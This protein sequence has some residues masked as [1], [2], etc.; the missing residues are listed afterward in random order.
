[1][2]NTLGSNPTGNLIEI[3]NGKLYG[4][5]YGGGVFA[6]FPGTLF[7]FDINTN[8]LTK[9][10]DFDG[11]LLG[12]NPYPLVN[13][14]NGKLYGVCRNG[15]TNV[16]TNPNNG[17]TYTTHNGTLFEYTPAT[18]VIN[19]LYDFGPTNTNGILADSGS[20]P[21]SLMKTSNGYYMGTG[22]Q[23]PFKFDPA[24]NT[25][26]NTINSN[27]PFN[28]NRLL[29]FIEICRK[30]SYQEFVVNTLSPA[31]GTAFTY[32]VNNTNAATYVWKKGTTVLPTQTTGVLNLPSVTLN[33]TGIYTCNMTNE[34][35]TTITANLNINV[36]NLAV[37]TVD[38]YKT[39]I[40]LYPNPTK[41]IINL[42]FPENRGLK[43]I[44][45]KII[46]LLGQIIIEND[47]SA[48]NKNELTI[49]TSS[50]ANGVY[51]LMLITD[52]GNWN[53]KFVKE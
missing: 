9:K 15:G 41:G 46:N 49:D 21:I 4:T 23:N 12:A 50:F 26:V 7:E 30:P 18:N 47:I 5:A 28:T 45:Y 17:I 38:D 31:V 43:G 24:D 52:K 25:V 22:E 53:G 37:E 48:S 27:I 19:K 14:G 2:I 3:G 29:N 1:V 44:K 39:L 20:N 11:N 13:G 42:K 40:S 6:G 16:F 51:Q 10:I 8:I 34:C 32:D 35:G 33:D 36:T